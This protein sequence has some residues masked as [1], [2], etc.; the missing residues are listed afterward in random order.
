MLHQPFCSAYARKKTVPDKMSE[1]VINIS[2]YRG[3]TQIER[4]LSVPIPLFPYTVIYAALVTGA[5]PAGGYSVLNDPDISARPR[6]SI[7]YKRHA[8]F[9]QPT[10]LCNGEPILTTLSHRFV[11]CV[12]D[13]I[14]LHN[15]T[16]VTDCQ[17]LFE[18]IDY[19]RRS[20]VR[21]MENAAEGELSGPG[22]KFYRCWGA[23]LI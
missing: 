4:E 12:S 9:H 11:I 16:F 21:W 13:L 7:R 1:T 18:K 22:M 20:M 5:V 6:K 2:Y 8:A 17:M 15:N 23:D 14:I 19:L 10:A 3:T